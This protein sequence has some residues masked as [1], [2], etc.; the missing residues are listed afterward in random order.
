M[1]KSVD[2]YLEEIDSLKEEIAKHQLNEALLKQLK[3]YYRVAFTH[4]SNAL[5]GNALTELETKIVLKERIAVNGKPLIHHLEAIGLSNSY[6]A[7]Y[8]LAHEKSITEDIIQQ[9]HWIFYNQ[10]DA[11]RAGK[12]RKAKVFIYGSK[13]PLPVPEEVPNLMKEWIVETLEQ[14]NEIHPVVFAALAHKDF[15]CIHP[16]VGGN[17]RV[18]RLLMNLI[19]LQEGY[20]IT[21]IPPVMRPEYIRALEKARVDDTDFVRFIAQMVKE[22]QMDYLCMVE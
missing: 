4:S 21:L 16:F 9:L 6:D 19:L 22:S 17:G 13:Y 2:R 11:T 12:Y 10:I 8:Q 14:R 20:A 3:E 1:V 7:L 15:V 18:A 5:E